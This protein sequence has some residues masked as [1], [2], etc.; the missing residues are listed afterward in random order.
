MINSVHIFCASNSD[1]GRLKP[2]EGLLKLVVIVPAFLIFTV[3]F[4][5][6]SIALFAPLFSYS[7]T[8]FGTV[9]YLFSKKPKGERKNEIQE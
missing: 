4:L 3:N 9:K 6:R 7:I 5:R 1:V 2:N 8:I